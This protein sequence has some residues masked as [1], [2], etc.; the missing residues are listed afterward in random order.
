V[1]IIR[2]DVDGNA[3]ASVDAYEFLV[4]LTLADGNER[5]ETSFT[6]DAARALAAV[7]VHQASEV[8]S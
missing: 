3:Q 7:L 1:T 2:I 6:P 4:H 8:E 5:L